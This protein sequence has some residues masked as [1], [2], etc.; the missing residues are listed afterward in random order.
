MQLKFKWLALIE[1]VVIL[2][3]L[4]VL[5]IN[6]NSQKTEKLNNSP[7][8]KKQNYTGLLSTR[9]YSGILEPKSLLIVNFDPLRRRLIEYIRE[10]NLNI[11]IYIVN[12]RDG[13]SIGIRERRGFMPVSL[14]KVPVAIL[15]MKKIERGELSFDTM[16]EIK[17]SDRTDTFGSLYKTT[18]KKLPLRILL[19]KMVKESD[20]TAFNA[21]N[22]H[23]DEK[24]LQFLLNY[25]DYHSK[26]II[27][28]YPD[29]ETKDKLEYVNTKSIYNLFSSLY[30]STLLEP[31]DSEYI[32]SLLTETVFDI[33]QIAKLPDNVIVVQK[34][35]AEYADKRKYFHSC[36][37]MYID[38]SRIFYCILTE[39]LE[40]QDAVKAISYVI[41]LVHKYIIDV[42]NELDSYRE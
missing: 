17:D 38:K 14:N 32:L 36:G 34:F 5:I 11:S 37:I 16:I 3:L 8:F 7:E 2:I 42:R 12:L 18:E 24:D 4:A 10:N 31:K 25:L 20:N 29:N 41:N 30:L 26:D 1:L 39:N 33:K 27:L 13:A 23:T 19:E 21:L 6:F 15:I 9:V 22:R 35:G 28:P 40:Q